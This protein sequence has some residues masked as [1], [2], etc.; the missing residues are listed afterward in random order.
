[1]LG[2]EGQAEDLDTAIST[3][4]KTLEDYALAQDEAKKKTD[5]HTLAM[6]TLAKSN[7]RSALRAL[8]ESWKQY[9]KQ[10]EG[11]T[12][13][14]EMVKNKIK[15]LY[16]RASEYATKDL[17]LIG[18]EDLEDISDYDERLTTLLVTLKK[19]ADNRP[20]YKDGSIDIQAE[21]IYN[22]IDSM[23]AYTIK[24]SELE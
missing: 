7:A 13:S 6:E 11:V 23:D 21:K 4:N 8:S 9:E 20:T 22:L 19:Y 10:S 18:K 14:T 16:E 2:Q 3:L 5:A 24:L 17:K 1:M 12:S 15:E